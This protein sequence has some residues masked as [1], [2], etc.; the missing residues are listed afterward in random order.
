MPKGAG[1]QQQKGQRPLY[2]GRV[3]LDKDYFV[4]NGEKISVR[5]GM[6]AV[7]EIVVQKRR[8]VD[9][10]LDPFRRLKG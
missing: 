9:L 6:T 3:S 8:L 1:Q 4:I 10:V 7:T 2:E 5:Y